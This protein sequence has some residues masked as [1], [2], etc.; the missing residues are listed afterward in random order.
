MLIIQN[1]LFYLITNEIE[2]SAIVNLVYLAARDKYRVERE[3][4]AGKGY[5]DFIFYPEKKNSSA[6]ILELKVDASPEE[7]I[8][9][10]KD[11]HI[12]YVLKEN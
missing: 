8:Q 7:A 4:K 12:F 1:L 11:K 6:I 5:V 10:I 2:L 9:Q 3:D